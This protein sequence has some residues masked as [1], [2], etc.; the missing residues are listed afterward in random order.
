MIK[1]MEIMNPD[2]CLNRA[3]HDELIFVL[4]ARDAA[5]PVAIRAWCEE[6]VRIGKNKW[7]DEQIMEALACAE[8]MQK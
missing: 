3:R 5:A 2:S 8:K 1:S 6:R 7:G 4:L